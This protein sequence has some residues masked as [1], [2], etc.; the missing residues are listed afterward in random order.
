MICDIVE[1]LLCQLPVVAIWKAGNENV[2][3]RELTAK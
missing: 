2:L 3:M 1:E